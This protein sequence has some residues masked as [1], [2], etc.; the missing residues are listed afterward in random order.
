MV[1]ASELQQHDAVNSAAAARS[2]LNHDNTAAQQNTEEEIDWE[3]E[4][5]L[6]DD[7]NDN[8]A[9]TGYTC[10][11][12]INA[13]YE[14]PIIRVVPDALVGRYFEGEGEST[15]A[16]QGEIESINGGVENGNTSSKYS[17]FYDNNA[18]GIY[19][20]SIHDHVKCEVSSRQK[21]FDDKLLTLLMVLN[22]YWSEPFQE[23][24]ACSKLNIESKEATSYRCVKAWLSDVQ[25]NVMLSC[26]CCCKSDR[27]G[28]HGFI[29]NHFLR[30]VCGLDTHWYAVLW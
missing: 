22:E 7:P 8:Q 5:A 17:E 26:P 21:V 19:S 28:A 24:Y 18:M 29:S 14:P 15:G 1:T 6:C 9:T 12:N 4:A 30:C 3:A 25:Y 20:K 2:R 23:K 10:P 11:P 13:L 16:T 27:V